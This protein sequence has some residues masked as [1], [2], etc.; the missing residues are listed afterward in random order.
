MQRDRVADYVHVSRQLRCL[1][2]RNLRAMGHGHLI[3]LFRYD[4]SHIYE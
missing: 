1:P 2:K 4:I 3:A